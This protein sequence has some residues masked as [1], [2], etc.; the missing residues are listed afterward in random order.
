[1]L[2]GADKASRRIN[3]KQGGKLAGLLRNNLEKRVRRSARTD[4]AGL[5]LSLK[6]ARAACPQRDVRTGRGRRIGIP[7]SAQVCKWRGGAR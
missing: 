5:P 6:T 3:L 1:M 4:S 2:D 7:S